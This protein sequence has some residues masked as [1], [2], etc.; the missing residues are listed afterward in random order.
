MDHVNLKPTISD[1]ENLINRKGSTD[2]FTQL[3]I[4]S[5]SFASSQQ[6]IT[7]E[8]QLVFCSQYVFSMNKRFNAFFSSEGIAHMFR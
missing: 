6:E 1:R 3:G 7:N 8:W 2:D 4:L 5:Y